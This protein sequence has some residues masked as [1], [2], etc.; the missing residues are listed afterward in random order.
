MKT[1]KAIFIGVLS[2]ISMIA[3]SQNS[4]HKYQNEL[5][6]VKVVVLTL[7][8]NVRITPSHDYQIIVNSTLTTQGKVRGI[9]TPKHRPAFKTSSK[10]SN[11]TLYV[12]TAPI[13]NYSTIG[14]STYTETIETI[15]TISENTELIIDNS[16]SVVLEPGFSKVNI[17]EAKSIALNNVKKTQLQSLSC[18]SSEE[19]MINGYSKGNSYEFMG[20]G[21]ENYL[22]KA[23]QIDITIQ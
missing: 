10:L 22:L 3:N 12:I 4:V 8:G 9:K 13:F 21:L 19:I 17:R 5:E 11:D 2:T 23:K 7:D 16:N 18:E 1:R 15:I 14:V 20:V 6:N